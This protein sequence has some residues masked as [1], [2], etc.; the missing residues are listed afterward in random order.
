M[1]LTEILLNEVLLKEF[2]GGGIF[3]LFGVV[4]LLEGG[5]KNS[6]KPYQNP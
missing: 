3:F 4:I 2:W 1:R 5:G 6:Y